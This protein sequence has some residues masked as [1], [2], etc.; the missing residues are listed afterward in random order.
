M[1]PLKI[2]IWLGG[3]GVLLAACGTTQEAREEDRALEDFKAALA[4]RQI[5]RRRETLGQCLQ[6]GVI[7]PEDYLQK[8][9]RMLE[10]YVTDRPPC[11]I[12]AVERTRRAEA[13]FRALWASMMGRPVPV[14][15]EWLLAVKRRIAELIDGGVI[16]TDQGRTILFE[17]QLI[18]ADRDRRDE[19]P[20]MSEQV[21]QQGGEA[22]KILADLNSALNSSLDEQGIDCRRAGDRRPC[23]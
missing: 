17:A 10:E 13:D 21:E 8:G 23:F 15:Y 16:T 22:A 20:P 4:Q 3:L 9:G 14:G 12:T 7:L 19:M 18:L 5:E 1:P 11:G 6:R 2:F